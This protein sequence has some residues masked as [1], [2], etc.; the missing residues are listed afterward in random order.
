MAIC[1]DCLSHNV[2]LKYM[3]NAGLQNIFETAISNIDA[4]YPEFKDKSKIIE[5]PE[6]SC[7]N[8]I[9]QH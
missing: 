8:V 9:L 2:C 6:N 7:V 1:E 4:P 5:L 3:K